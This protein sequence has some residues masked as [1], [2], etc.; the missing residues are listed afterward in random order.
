MTEPI[1]Q[2]DPAAVVALTEALTRAADRL[3]T[4]KRDRKAALTDGKPKAITE[5]QAR[6][7]AAAH[8]RKTAVTKLGEARAAWWRTKADMCADRFG[9]VCEAIRRARADGETAHRKFWGTPGPVTI[10]TKQ[11]QGFARRLRGE[12]LS[13][14]GA[15]NGHSLKA[16][17][18]TIA[19][20]EYQKRTATIPS[21]SR[22][23]DVERLRK[24]TN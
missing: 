9:E 7:L 24:E 2:P 11:L 5:A 1:P 6:V 20:D 16:G 22:A 10:E 4:A 3:A 15:A 13:A 8:A 18:P 14:I 17:A 12:C 23:E 21:G 19:P